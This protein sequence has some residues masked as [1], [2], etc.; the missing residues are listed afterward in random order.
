[1]AALMI[2]SVSVAKSQ[3]SQQLLVGHWLEGCCT[4]ANQYQVLMD[5]A[6]CAD[7]DIK[8]VYWGFPTPPSNNWNIYY[9]FQDSVYINDSWSNEVTTPIHDTITRGVIL[10]PFPDTLTF[11]IPHA[12]LTTT[13]EGVGVHMYA[14]LRDNSTLKDASDTGVNL[15]YL[16]FYV[17]VGIHKCNILST[18]ITNLTINQHIVDTK[19]INF[20]GQ[21]LPKPMGLCVQIDT[22]DDGSVKTKEIVVQ[23]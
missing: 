20:T 12:A 2:L 23:Q 8:L 22:Y 4:N 5:T 7:D 15:E 3:Y 10:A 19:W 9:I 14:V 18:Q 1:M 13:Y 16:D 21:K 6:F 17:G 11:L